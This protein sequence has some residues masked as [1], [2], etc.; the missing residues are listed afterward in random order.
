[1][2]PLTLILMLVMVVLN[3]VKYKPYGI[4]TQNTLIVM[5]VAGPM[6]GAVSYF[7]TVPLSFLPSKVSKKLN[8]LSTGEIDLSN[9][10]KHTMAV[11]VGNQNAIVR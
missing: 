2:S 6:G 5:I 3:M 11:E 8:C 1:M 4:F 9:R 10:N 7:L